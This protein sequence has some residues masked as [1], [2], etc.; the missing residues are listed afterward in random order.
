ML[1]HSKTRV[2]LPLGGCQLRERVMAAPGALDSE[3]RFSTSPLH[4]A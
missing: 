2:R 4:Y 3:I 1:V